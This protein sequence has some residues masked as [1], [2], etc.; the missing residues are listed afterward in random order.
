MVIEV[1]D[2]IANFAAIVYLHKVRIRCKCCLKKFLCCKTLALTFARN[3][4]RPMT[5]QMTN[6][7]ER[8]EMVIRGR[9]KDHNAG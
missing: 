5:L 2:C 7:H 1:R 4:S 9:F 3:T 6:Q 8:S